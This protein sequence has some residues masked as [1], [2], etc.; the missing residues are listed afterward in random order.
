MPHMTGASDLRGSWCARTRAHRQA[1]DSSVPRGARLVRRALFVAIV[2]PIVGATACASRPPEEPGALAPPVDASMDDGDLFPVDGPTLSELCGAVPSTLDDWERCYQRRW[3]EWYVA[4][5]PQGPY[6]GIPECLD[7]SP[8]LDGGRLAAELRERQRAVAQGRASLDVA[9]FTQCLADTSGALCNTARF[10]VACANRFTGSEGDGGA[11]FADVECASPGAT[12]EASCS[13]ACCPGTCRPRLRLGEACALS[14]A[15]APGL[16][17]HG[18]CQSGDIGAPCAS[19]ADCDSNAWCDAGRCRADLA[20]DAACT[21]VLQCG[22]QTSCLGLSIV[23]SAPGRCLSMAKP[24]DRCDLFCYGNLYCDATATCRE[25]PRLGQPCG[26]AAS[27]GGTDAICS[28]GMCVLRADAG[29]ACAS[30]RS[31]RPGLFCTSELHDPQPTCA[32]PAST[33]YP[34]VDPGH[35]ESY[36]CSGEPGMPGVCLPWSESCPLVTAPSRPER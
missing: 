16:V 35:C 30:R 25:L 14:G 12:C 7:D 21:S 24:G 33:G 23:D 10:S 13:D 26:G 11:C 27:C 5:A 9:A 34:C 3:C 6:R 8:R 2:V 32:P 28:N 20:P 17:C 31:C 1:I 36:R 19:H 22:G 15:C 18:T 29:A 4:C